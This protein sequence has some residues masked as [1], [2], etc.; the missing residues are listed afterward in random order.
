MFFYP[1]KSMQGYLPALEGMTEEA[2]AT[3][4]DTYCRLECAPPLPV[5][6]C[7]A[8]YLVGQLEYPTNLV[9]FLTPMT[10]NHMA[11]IRGDMPTSFSTTTNSISTK[12]QFHFHNNQ[13]HF[14]NNQHHGGSS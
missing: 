6:Q 12:N 3:L 14:H 9:K 8:R 5:V 11:V 10:P 4:Y 2:L 13:F 7:I 1:R